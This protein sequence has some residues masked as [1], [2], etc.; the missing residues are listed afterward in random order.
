MTNRHDIRAAIRLCFPP[1][2]L[3]RRPLVSSEALLVLTTC[4]NAQEATRLAEVL[5]EHR[6][7]ACVSR[8]E[9]IVS[10][11]RWESKIQHEEAVLVLV[12]T[13]AACYDA[14]EE[15]IRKLTSYEL[16][17]ILAVP[18]QG[19]SAEYIKWLTASVGLEE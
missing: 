6:L 18:V 5:L 10:S 8:L 1:D 2:Q 14:L 13:T 11:Y 16:P 15:M 17:E 7:A 4:G 9:G 19:G 12:K 3:W